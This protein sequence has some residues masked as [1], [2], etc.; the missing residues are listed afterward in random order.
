M[1]RSTL[2]MMAFLLLVASQLM[3]KQKIGIALS[4]GGARCLAHIGVLKVF[5]EYGIVPDQ[6]SGTSMGAVIATFYALGWTPDEIADLFRTNDWRQLLNG[7]I[8]RED[9]YTGEKRW[10][11]N[12]N[13]YFRIDD[14]FNPQLPRSFL[15]GN[16]LL[17]ELFR[18]TFPYTDA[19]SF[20]SLPISLRV[21]AT[22][23]E[24]GEAV[25]FRDGAL[26]EVLLASLTFPSVLAPF[27]VQGHYCADGGIVMNLPIQAL[28]DQDICIGVKTSSA[29]KP[30]HELNDVIDVLNQSM[31]IN[32]SWRVEQSLPE[33][34]CLICPEL[35][36]T[37]LFDFD[38]ADRIIAAGEKAARAQI[39]N[40]LK[41]R[42]S[43]SGNKRNELTE[44]E[45]PITIRSVEVEGNYYL[46]SSKIRE[47]TGIKA[48]NTY[49]LEDLLDNFDR[50]FHSRLFEYIYPVL[51][52]IDNGY[53]LSIRL[54]ENERRKLG[55]NARYNNTDELTIGG[56]LEYTN[57]LQRNSKLIVNVDLGGIQEVNVDYVK[58]FGKLWGVYFRV[59]PYL[60]Y[61][62][63]FLYDDM[64]EKTGS[65]RSRE[66]GANLGVGLYAAFDTIFEGFFYSYQ[67]EFYR[68]VSAKNYVENYNRSTGVG[69]KAYSE[70]Y[71]DFM[72]P[73]RGRRIMMK[74]ISATDHF[75]SDASYER[76]LAHLSYV[77]PAEEEHLA[78]RA[79]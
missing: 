34:D 76:Y 55:L 16:R 39:D 22:D 24:T 71:D 64:H 33:C 52:P 36:D 67:R 48:G 49:S 51:I 63:F 27:K 38:Q 13:F 17:L 7:T 8:S 15:S 2:I 12:A 75:Y 58:N 28:D 35:D 44:I 14:N 31:N 29:L 5:D 54:K 79:V 59:F 78:N 46:S 60:R 56:S 70:T 20:D 65:I 23:I 19:T 6:I 57:Y 50:A 32:M 47:Y 37:G 68:D 9:F 18:L 66:A 41:L 11:P 26:H 72:I 69:L 74:F 40:L 1:K 42:D 43:G 73:M 61:E 25:I 62:R 45:G 30:T 10:G 53:H 4:G 3:S 77:F 21:V